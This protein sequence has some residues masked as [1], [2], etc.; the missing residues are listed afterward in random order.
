[1]RAL[2][3]RDDTHL[4]T[5]CVLIFASIADLIQ[6]FH[7]LSESILLAIHTAEQRVSAEPEP[8][9]SDAAGL[10]QLHGVAR[11]EQSLQR[12]HERELKQSK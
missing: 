3:T 9:H 2:A 8:E 11:K 5:I 4:L 7:L 1:M 6:S 10:R 12:V